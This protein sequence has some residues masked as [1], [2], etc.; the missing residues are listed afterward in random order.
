MKTIAVVNQKGGCGKTT[1]AV[2]LAAALAEQQQNV[3]LMD[4]D[5]QA[6]ATLGFGHDPDD[7]R[8]T[9]YEALTNSRVP[10]TDVLRSTTTERLTL[11]PSN[12][13]LASAD[14]ELAHAANRELILSQALRSV[15]ARFDVC[16]MDCA[17]SFG[18]LTI[19]AL[20]A[21]TD[22]IVPVQPHYYSMEGLRRVLETIRLIRGRFHPS[23]AGNLNVLLTLV[24][25]RT[26]LSKQ[27]QSQMREIFGAMVFQTVIHNNVRLC[28]AP[29]AG[30][31]I[32]DYAPRSRGALEYRALAAEVL[33]RVPAVATFSRS[34][35][36]R[37]I[38][39][40][41]AELFGGRHAT[42]KP[43]APQRVATE[44]GLV[45]PPAADESEPSEERDSLDIDLTA[46]GTLDDLDL[47]HAEAILAATCGAA[48]AALDS[49]PQEPETSA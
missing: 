44:S 37:G 23:S 28:E 3:L 24:E 4:L 18:I 8:Q 13:M 16:V 49:L 36:R 40:D 9:V 29:S 15:R 42:A 45:G 33:G 1:T 41:L 5:P 27:I 47:E 39:K 46:T 17:P 10:L 12:V 30:E 11:A 22:V 7:L 48:S 14:V 38:Q 6:H 31:S 43:A 20:I 2:N 34:S 26:T 32:L 35:S 21:S 25:D 19:S